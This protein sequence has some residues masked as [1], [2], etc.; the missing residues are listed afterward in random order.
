MLPNKIHL[1]SIKDLLKLGPYQKFKFEK[2]IKNDK[3]DIY[4]Y[5]GQ[6]RSRK[7][8]RVQ[9]IGG[10]H[11][12]DVKVDSFYV[13]GK[14]GPI[15]MLFRARTRPDKYRIVCFPKPLR[16]LPKRRTRRRKTKVKQ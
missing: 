9:P 13:F 8:W 4:A 1:A 7:F 15:G 6:G 10:T 11:K 12:T 5:V 14:E 16:R 2:D 3:T